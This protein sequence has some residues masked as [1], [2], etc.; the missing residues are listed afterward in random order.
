[1]KRSAFCLGLV[2]V[3]TLIFFALPKSEAL[4]PDGPERC[5]WGEFESIDKYQ[6]IMG[7]P[8]AWVEMNG[9]HVRVFVPCRGS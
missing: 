8:K 6:D 2:V 5:F 4:A 9:S 1:M 3:A 7:P